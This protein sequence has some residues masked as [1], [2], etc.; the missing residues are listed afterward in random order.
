[1][2]PTTALQMQ[3]Y[4]E[5]VARLPSEH[6]SS[7]EPLGDFLYY[8]RTPHRRDLPLYCRTHK[9]GG[10]EQILLDLGALA[11]AHGFAGLGSLSISSDQ[12]MLAFTV[13]LSGA[14]RY[15][16]RV[17]DLASGHVVSSRSNAVGVEWA[18]GHELVYTSADA[19]ARPHQALL[20][21]AGSERECDDAV[22]LTD[23]DEAAAIDIA[24]TKS[25][26]WLTINSNTL[27]SSEVHLLRAD[28]PHHPNSMEGRRTPSATAS[29]GPS[30]TPSAPLLVMPRAAG[31]TYFVEQL[32]TDGWLLVAGTLSPPSR[33][34]GLGGVHER[35]LPLDSVEACAPLLR[36]RGES[37]IEDVDVFDGRVV[38]YERDRGVPRIRL[39]RVEPPSAAAANL[40]TLLED[41]FVP[42]PPAPT[43]PPPPTTS[44]TPT[45]PPPP[46]SWLGNVLPNGADGALRACGLLP[47]AVTPAPNRDF[48]S[49]VVHFTHSSPTS[50][51]T[52]YA[53]HLLEHRL[54]ARGPPTELPS[55]IELACELVHA[56]ARD[57]TQVPMHACASPRARAPHPRPRLAP[58][59]PRILSSIPPHTLPTRVPTSPSS[60]PSPWRRSR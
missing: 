26:R 39:L 55:P 42:L 29:A 23:E 27:S 5:M 4:D 28:K 1:M 43:Q 19:R 22:L 57:G 10:P 15:E 38:L 33:A 56:T 8:T 20:H 45:P 37:P 40:P 6:T 32:T 25:R 47:C 49:T 36:A 16:L 51:P 12:S 52:P 58:R 41:G 2:R 24:L 46:K 35:A 50:P 9:G 34:I 11:D 13:D 53:Y 18:C 59:P 31:V 7:V 30:A 54:E 3:L 17:V 60:G 21:M 14:E 44:P 48:D